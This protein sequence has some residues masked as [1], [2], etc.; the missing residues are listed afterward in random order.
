MKTVV[1]FIPHL[2]VGGAE[3]QLCLL[4][5]RLRSAGWE[6]VVATIEDFHGIAPRLSASGVEVVFLPR[7]RRAGW[8]TVAAL[9]RLVRRRQARVIHA[10]L[11]ASNW[12]AAVAR[13][14]APQVHVVAS[15]RSTEDDLG[16]W[17]LIAY[18]A[19]APLFDAII[20]NSRAVRERSAERT[21]ISRNTYRLVPNGVELDRLD[22][23]SNESVVIPWDPEPA[24]VVGFVGTLSRRKRA[25]SLA[26][27]A[28][29]ILARVPSARFLIVGDGPEREPLEAACARLAIA[30]RFAFV[31]YAERVAPFL[32]RM[33]V[34]VHPSTNEGSSNSILEAMAARIPVVAYAVSG[35][36]E[37]VI[38]GATGSLVEDGREDELAAAS[39]ELL[40]NPD[41][42]RRRGSA[43]RARIE[44]EFSVDAMVRATTAVYEAVTSPR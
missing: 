44:R 31:G 5:P 30:D 36:R 26:P 27:L 12:R 8:D 39:V 2:G 43:G 9:A 3:L 40:E 37:T 42:A 1:L 14:L 24:P 6:P 20:V 4:A 35:N 15:I 22:R 28:A 16:P 38:H 21:G 33:N 29:R 10:W 34:L 7:A 23:E 32:R 13:L 18:R 17:H 41:E 19:M 25:A 11:W